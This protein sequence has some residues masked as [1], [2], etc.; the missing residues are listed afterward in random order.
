MSM[1]DNCMISEKESHYL[2][3]L[4]ITS[5]KLKQANDIIER[6]SI[7]IF[8][9]SIG[10]G[11]PV[12]LVTK[13]I[14]I[15]GYTEEEFYSEVVDYWDF[16]YEKDVEKTQKIVWGAREKKD[17]YE[18]KHV[19]RVKCK[20]G[21]IRWVEEWTILERDSTG[22]L[23][24]EKGVLRDITEQV[25]TSE[26]LRQ[27]EERYRSLFDN[28]GALI[29]TIDVHGNF[30]SVNNACINMTG[31][32][33]ET[34]LKMKPKDL[35]VLEEALPLD[36][37]N[38]MGF[39]IAH[40]G[41]NMQFSVRSKNNGILILEGRATISYSE[42]EPSEFQIIAQD[43]TSRIIAEKKIHHLT[44]HDKLTNLYNRAYFDDALQK[45]EQKQ[46]YPCSIII[47]DMNGLKFA[48]DTFGHKI[49]DCLLKETA[50][51]LKA[52]CPCRSI[53]ARLSG[54]E[55]AIIIPNCSE[56]EAMKICKTIK[57]LCSKSSNHPIR[58]SIALGYSTRNDNTKTLEA[59]VIEADDNMYKNKLNDST[60][61]R[62]A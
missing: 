49:G 31:Y 6:S 55:F 45:L 25:E 53:V 29:F 7:I 17:L 58:P 52:C 47:G 35:L 37:D 12:K 32:D 2:N 50:N 48:N 20:N 56:N 26:R 42:G 13:N 33:R 22:E 9:W 18:Y 57:E 16:V 28:A 54:D 23:V 46:E 36:F 3:E 14:S 61:T 41:T 44:F 51:I 62:R 21:D 19:Y 43:V 24:S 10:P 11:I 39:F 27:S 8:E 38:I 15:F 40:L 5:N 34:L 30:T 59:L 60:K 1:N 4:E